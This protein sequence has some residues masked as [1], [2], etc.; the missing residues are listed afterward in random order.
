MASDSVTVY[1]FEVLDPEEGP[2]HMPFKA[3]R[4]SIASCG[5]ARLIDGTG[6]NVEVSALDAQ[7]RYY[8]HVGG[9]ALEQLQAIA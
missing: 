9:W 4:K 7:G 3:T 6:E 5:N 1:S 2:R 8:R